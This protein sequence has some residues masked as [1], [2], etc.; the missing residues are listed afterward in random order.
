MAEPGDS[1][2][3]GTE[4]AAPAGNVDVDSDGSGGGEAKPDSDP[5]TSKVGSDPE[6]TVGKP[7]DDE[8]DDEN[9]EEKKP[10]PGVGWP[11]YKHSIAIPVFRFPGPEEVTDTGWP[12]PSAFFYTVEVPLTFEGFLSAFAQPE[13]EPTPGPAFRGQQEAPVIDV[14]GGAGGGG[15]GVEPAAAGGGSPPVFRVPVVVA[16]AV[17]IPGRVAPTTPVGGPAAG[18][19]PPPVAGAPTAV[20][21]ANAPTVRGSLSPKTETAKTE[22]TPMSGQATRLGYPRS[23]P[24][25]TVGQLA[26]VALPGVGALMFVTFSGG[27]IGYRQANSLR[28]VRTAGAE[29]FLP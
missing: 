29:R 4:G 9:V 26:V 8:K 7:A 14:T 22:M 17:P 3:T 6:D 24:N 12:D 2:D 19:P 10:E 13:P 18:A 15:G 25:P 21:G 23:L 20:A 11:K 5:P 27:V 16:P 1:T 28:F